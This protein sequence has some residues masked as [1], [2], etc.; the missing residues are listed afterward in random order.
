[1]TAI[2]YPSGKVLGIRYGTG[3]DKRVTGY[4]LAPNSS[5]A[6]TPLISGIQYF[7]L[8]GPESW[9]LGGTSGSNTKD[10]TRLIDQNSR[11][12]KYTT[13]SGY[14]ALTFDN[15]GRITGIGD[16]LGTATT[17][18]ATQAFGYDN[19]G[20]LTNFLGFTSNGINATTG[21]GNASITQSQSFTYDNNGN[22]L[23]SNLN[24]ITS[25]YSY[26]AGSNKLASIATA[27]G[28]PASTN[29]TR[30]NTLD[31][32]GNLT[33]IT[34]TTS[35]SQT[36]PMT[37]TYDDRA[38]LKTALVNG[39]TTIYAINY[40]QLRVRKGN[41][42]TPSD[43]SNTRLFIYDDA[44]HMLGEYDHQGNAIQ[45]L[46][47]LNDTPVA[48]TGT[49]PCLTSTTNT[50]TANGAIG[51]P[52][53]TEDATAFIFTD[54]LNTP[55][56]IARIGASAANGNNANG[57]T[58]IWKWD[59][60]PFGE[61]QPNQ[62][63]SSLG[64]LNF[65]HRFPG[66]YYDRE[67]G[68]SQNWHREYDASIGRYVQSDPI[69]LGGGV[70]TYGYVHNSP[71]SASDA[72]GQFALTPCEARWLT[73]TYG[74]ELASLYAGVNFHQAV[75]TVLEAMTT[76]ARSAMAALSVALA[77]T[78]I[79]QILKRYTNFTA[80]DIARV[81]L[82]ATAT[83]SELLRNPSSYAQMAARTATDVTRWLTYGVQ[84]ARGAGA[85][86]L[87]GVAGSLAILQ[88][89]SACEGR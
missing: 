37:L 70:N 69:G 18:S 9:I 21:Q 22:R 11:I 78:A 39:T 35:G 4:T 41:A 48:V 68:L 65:N 42:T 59:S 12:Q 31:A 13:P 27:G 86:G 64:V 63:P 72:S 73:S 15:A 38:R 53:C 49:L 5:T 24:G 76:D 61:T 60:L 19:A 28:G 55:R 83:L 46:I 32:M 1:V 62:N 17:A 25:T 58:T 40:Q 36:L 29:L 85:L 80:R 50:N 75:H 89:Q 56:E 54:H 79:A 51:N 43:T 26:S 88:A 84:I 82:S 2:T 77:P 6:G 45:E 47:W 74:D 10:Y 52:T 57:Y 14:R 87:F 66:Q 33:S 7:P 34:G 44:G 81:C 20:R 30:T 16:Y 23:T 3:S 8:G 71:L 67:T